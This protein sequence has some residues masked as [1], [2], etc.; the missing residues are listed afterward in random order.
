MKF[1]NRKVILIL[2]NAG[3][4][5]L[6]VHEYSNVKLVYLAPNMTS[7]LQPCDAGIIKSF[8][9]QYKKILV[10]SFIDSYEEKKKN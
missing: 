4:H 8:K 2:D 10:K 9:A 7:Q 3:G 1:K 5:N 6:S